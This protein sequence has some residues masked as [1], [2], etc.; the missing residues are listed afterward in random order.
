MGPCHTDNDCIGKL[1]GTYLAKYSFYFFTL[2]ECVTAMDVY[3]AQ[4]D[5][6][7]VYQVR[8]VRKSSGN[9]VK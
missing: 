9:L 1:H 3:A 6:S 4:G 2:E 5:G 8:T 7:R